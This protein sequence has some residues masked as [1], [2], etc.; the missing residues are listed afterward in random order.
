MKQNQENFLESDEEINTLVRKHFSS[1]RTFYKKG[2]VQSIFNFC[3]NEDLK[4]LIPKIVNQILQLQFNRFKLNYSF[5]YILRNISNEEL[6]YYHTSNNNSLMM[7]TT[8]LISNRQELI[9]FLNTLAEESF[10]DKINRPDTK[11]KVIDIPNITFYVNH[12]KDA[13]LGAPIYLPDY[14]KNNRGL[15]NVSA[16]DHLCF[17]RCLAVHQGADPRWCEQP[18]KNLFHAYCDRFD[19]VPEQFAGVQLFDFLHLQNFF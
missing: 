6:R 11:W 3:Y 2:K 17:F 16:G 7:S 1:I 13:P 9:Q 5:A 8:R 19:I 10:S 12:V 14:I 15:Q 4:V 18:V